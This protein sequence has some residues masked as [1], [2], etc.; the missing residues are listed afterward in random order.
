M[1]KDL[2]PQLDA[3]CVVHGKQADSGAAGGGYPHDAHTVKQKVVSPPVA[4]GVEERHKFTAEGIHACKVR[5]L[6]KITAVTGK[7]KVVDF[8][9]PAVLFSQDM[10]DVVSQFAVGLGEQAVFA[11]VVRST[12]DKVPRSGIHC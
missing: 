11:T 7:R 1:G 6:A 8:I 4:S 3:A 5:A 12:S 9:A 2:G 10:L